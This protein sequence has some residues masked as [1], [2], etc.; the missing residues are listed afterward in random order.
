[1]EQLYPLH[2]KALVAAMGEFPKAKTFVWCQEESANMGS[3]GYIQPHLRRLLGD[4]PVV[5]AGRGASASP[6]VGSL[7]IHKQE[8]K[9]LVQ[10][11]F[12]LA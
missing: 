8:Q 5:Y 3:W 6:A 10:E 4:K 2:E 11:A 7:G 1:M 9:Q 12:T